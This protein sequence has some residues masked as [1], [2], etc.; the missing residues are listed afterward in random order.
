M[1]SYYIAV[2]FALQ[3]IHYLLYSIK[4]IAHSQSSLPDR[5]LFI[6]LQ[7]SI[8]LLCLPSFPFSFFHFSVFRCYHPY[9]PII[10]LLSTGEALSK[11]LFKDNRAFLV[12]FGKAI[13]TM[14][15]C[16][17]FNIRRLHVKQFLA[18]TISSNAALVKKIANKMRAKASAPSKPLNLT[19][20]A[21][22]PV[23]NL[24][25]MGTVQVWQVL[26]ASLAVATYVVKNRHVHK[27][28]YTFFC[29]EQSSVVLI[30]DV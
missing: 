8:F 29:V 14:G 19:I 10:G 30:N 1:I 21:S 4:H 13:K 18:W 22:F 17:H 15:F 20:V 6:P 25:Q 2:I 28:F 11:T 12:H 3:T 16:A 24:Q 9:P 5:Y 23:P 7:N 27:F 26:R